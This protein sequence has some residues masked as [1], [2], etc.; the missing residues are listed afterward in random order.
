VHD[1]EIPKSDGGS[2]QKTDH[3]AVI[4]RLFADRIEA[5][6]HLVVRWGDGRRGVIEVSKLRERFRG[7]RS[8]VPAAAWSDEAIDRAMRELVRRNDRGRVPLT[9]GEM[10]EVMQAAAKAAPDAR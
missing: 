4:M 10:F 6:T 9:D 2:P 1:P 8:G 5:G 3:E 7:M